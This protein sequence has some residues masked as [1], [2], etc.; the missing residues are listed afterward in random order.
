MRPTD[1]STHKRSSTLSR[2][3]AVYAAMA[4]GRDELAGSL[5]DSLPALDALLVR[6]VASEHFAGS[7]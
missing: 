6:R 4:R 2:R 3:V 1:Q 7:L 5:F